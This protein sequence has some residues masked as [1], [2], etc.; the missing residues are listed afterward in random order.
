MSN[1]IYIPKGGMCKTC[2]HFNDDCS[3]FDFHEMKPIHSSGDGVIV[4]VRCNGYERKQKLQPP[5]KPVNLS[6]LIDSGIDVEVSVND[7]WRVGKLESIV[8]YSNGQPCYL[9]KGSSRGWAKCRPRVFFPHVI[10]TGNPVDVANE[11]IDAGFDI[12]YDSTF[13]GNN[14][15]LIFVYRGGILSGF[16]VPWEAPNA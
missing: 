15:L 3:H 11:F 2:K 8:S 14:E 1:K 10:E 16:C 13:F 5:K 12:E 9:I 6:V 7:K 4:T